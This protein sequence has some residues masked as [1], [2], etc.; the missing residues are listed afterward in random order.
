MARFLPL[1]LASGLV[2]V[3]GC[4]RQQPASPSEAKGNTGGPAK[5]PFA[6]SATTP[7]QPG[8]K[9][10]PIVQQPSSPV[11]PVA[12]G[13]K[14]ELGDSEGRPVLFFE[15]RTGL[16]VRVSDTKYFKLGWVDSY[17]ASIQPENGAQAKILV[18]TETPGGDGKAPSYAATIN[19]KP[20]PK[21]SDKNLVGFSLKDSVSGIVLA[22]PRANSRTELSYDPTGRVESQTTIVDG[23][24]TTRTKFSY[25]TTGRQQVAQQDFQNEG[26]TYTV[27]YSDYR[28][29]STGRIEGYTARVVKAE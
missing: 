29:D 24:G 7:R 22:R 25:D 19:G 12:Q 20:V 3:F 16:V 11:Q 10:P 15:L 6:D 5:P 18:R 13:P 27:S 4:D 9:V 28:W 23:V 21:Q 1:L 8:G 14:V 2:A 26:K 17:D